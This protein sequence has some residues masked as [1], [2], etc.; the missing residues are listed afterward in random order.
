M[1]I[2]G[3]NAIEQVEQF[4]TGSQAVASLVASS[5]YE[6]YRGTPPSGLGK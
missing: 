1:N 6:C 4:L 3:L 5:K 2:N